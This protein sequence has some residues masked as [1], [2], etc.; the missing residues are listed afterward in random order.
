MNGGRIGGPLG[1]TDT[2]SRMNAGKQRLEAAQVRPF[3]SEPMSW[4]LRSNSGTPETTRTQK[5]TLGEG[6]G[7]GGAGEEGVVKQILQAR[8]LSPVHLCTDT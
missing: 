8:C 7:Q 4:M 1:G 6:R 2:K 5:E 3:G